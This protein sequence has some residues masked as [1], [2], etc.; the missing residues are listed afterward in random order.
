MAKTRRLVL[1]VLKPHDPGKVRMA[2]E[3]A[4]LSSVS[5]VNCILYEVDKEVENIKLTIVG[6]DLNFDKIEDKIESLGGSIHSI[7]EIVAGENIID[8]VKTP[9]DNE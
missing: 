3:I 9:Q 6:P 2:N 8:E 7:D 1:D 4:D 5:S